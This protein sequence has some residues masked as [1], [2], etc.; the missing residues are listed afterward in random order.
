MAHLSAIA[1]ANLIHEVQ[2]SLTSIIMSGVLERFPKP[3]IVSAENDVDW[4]PHCIYRLDRAHEKFNALSSEPLPMKPSEYIRRQTFATFQ[5]DPVGPAA[6]KLFGS[7]NYMWASD[8]PHT[9]PT[10]PQSHQVVER[11]FAEVPEEVKRKIVFENAA[12]LYHIN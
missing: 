12:A 2:R 4:V 8:F 10:W 7:T 6:Y 9:D 5:D 1:Y 11:E 3:I